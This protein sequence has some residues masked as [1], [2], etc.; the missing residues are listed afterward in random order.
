VAAG[1]ALGGPLR[2]GLALEAEVIGRDAAEPYEAM[3]GLRGDDERR[4]RARVHWRH[5]GRTP[6]VVCFSGDLQNVVSAVRLPWRSG[7]VTDAACDR[8]GVVYIAGMAGRTLPRAGPVED[9]SAGPAAETTAYVA[10]LAP[11]LRSVAWIRT[12]ADAGN[13]PKV[14]INDRGEIGVEGGWLYTF[15]A[16]GRRL[17]V[18]ELAPIDSWVKARAVNP[19]D[20]TYT[21]G[22]DR[23][24]HTG[25][26]PWRCPVLHIGLPGPGFY[27][28][29]T[30][31]GPLVGM[32][33]IRLVSDSSIVRLHIGDDGILY[34]VGWSDGGN[35]CLEHQP[36]DLRRH[37]GYGGLGLQLWGVNSTSFCHLLKMDPVS[38]RV[39]GYTKWM[40]FRGSDGVPNGIGADLI[41]AATDGTV[42]VGGGS[43]FGVIQ[44]G[45]S[46]HRGD[47]GGSYIALFEP[48]FSTLRFSSVV[49]ACRAASIREG[50]HLGIAVGKQRGRHMALYVGGAARE[51]MTYSTGP[52]PP[53]SL[54]PFQ[55][56]F[57]GGATDGWLALFDLGPVTNRAAQAAGGR[58]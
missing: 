10:K 25:R 6:F 20:R 36:V 37:V 32:S 31:P 53:P 29:Y 35:S 57:G 55:P 58:P 42:L 18:T 39:R 9:V 28:L 30:W 56:E 1:T 3:Q 13:G 22:G 27:E 23:K 33:G 2:I 46:L 17:H 41:R 12:F 40:A 51:G 7:S 48:D 34:A 43:A 44:T 52:H 24:W 8:E 15:D 26:E 49:P 54:N 14:R 4:L 11:D 47:P 5:P 21:L 38:G 19:S 45:N 16:D 50:I